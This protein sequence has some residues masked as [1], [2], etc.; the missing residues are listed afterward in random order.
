MTE[1]KHTSGPLHHHGKEVHTN[2]VDGSTTVHCVVANCSQH[3]GITE[4]EAIA[5][6]AFFCKIFN[7]HDDLLEAM[8]DFAMKVSDIFNTISWS[9][10][11][12]AEKVYQLTISTMGRFRAAIAKAEEK[13]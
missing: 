1:T 8:N 10:E 13:P 12:Q 4:R 2:H 3:S 6:A 7:C 5:N 11:Q 9:R